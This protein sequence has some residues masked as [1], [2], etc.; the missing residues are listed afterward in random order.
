MIQWYQPVGSMEASFTCEVLRRIQLMDCKDLMDLRISGGLESL[1]AALI[2]E[3]HTISTT[4]LMPE[5]LRTFYVICKDKDC[6]EEVVFCGGNSVFKR[7]FDGEFS[8]EASEI[9][10]LILGHQSTRPACIDSLDNKI[11]PF[12]VRLENTDILLRQLEPTVHERGI[13]DRANYTVGYRL[14]GASLVLSLYI[15]QH[16]EFVRGKKV[17]E[18][19]A[20]VGLCGLVASK[21]GSSRTVITDFHCNVVDNIQYISCINRLACEAEILDWE[22]PRIDLGEFDLIIGS[23]IVCQSS[24]CDLIAGVL[25]KIFKPCT[26]A[27]ITLGS[28]DSRYGVED[29]KPVLES[30]GFIV[31]AVSNIQ[32]PEICLPGGI[33]ICQGIFVGTAKSYTHYI[34][35]KNCNNN[36]FL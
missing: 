9:M 3:S 10:S 15:L 27:W 18:I 11:R 30:R 5:L 16:Q 28:A 2:K 7:L 12:I 19:G 29:F 22:N 13:G 36:Y 23:D 20:G 34:I 17:L 1:V 4:I 24:D 32:V 25:L 35:T 6:A 31:D 33:E 21:V 14:W 26:V 8:E